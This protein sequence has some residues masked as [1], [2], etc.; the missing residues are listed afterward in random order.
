MTTTSDHLSRLLDPVTECLSKEGARRL[1]ELR[2]D[3]ATQARIDLLADKASDGS[4]LP[5][6]RDEYE[7]YVETI[8]FIGILQA[9]ARALLDKTS[10]G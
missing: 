10:Q 8:D 6:E 9:R 4:I 3:E 1:V 7:A 2:V 5:G